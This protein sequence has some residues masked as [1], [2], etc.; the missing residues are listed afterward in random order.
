MF[1]IPADLPRPVVPLA[2]LVGRWQGWGVQS[3]PGQADVPVLHDVIVKPVET[4]LQCEHNCYAASARV[5]QGI[6]GIQSDQ[7]ILGE[8]DPL[9]SAESGL[10]SLAAGE[11]LFTETSRWQVEDNSLLRS[12]LAMGA[13]EALEFAL[14]VETDSSTGLSIKWMGATVSGKITLTSQKIADN[15]LIGGEE[16]GLEIV[17]L[18]RMFGLVSGELMF[19]FDRQVKEADAYTALTGRLQRVEMEI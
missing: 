10:E 17:S 4:V 7:G 12:S 13:G 15:S 5:A 11:L 9:W 6:Q 18:S 1:E 3:V 16:S 19:A 14:E 8:F 2:W